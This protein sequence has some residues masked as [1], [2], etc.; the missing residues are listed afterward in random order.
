M[1]LTAP[2]GDGSETA[3]VD[4]GVVDVAEK[5]HGA[6]LVEFVAFV[7]LAEVGGVDQVFAYSVE[8]EE[9]REEGV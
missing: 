4:V 5:G 8:A 6:L 1:R 7:A 9:A 2:L 3:D